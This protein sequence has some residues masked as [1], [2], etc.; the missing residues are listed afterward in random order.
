MKID[1]DSEDGRLPEAKWLVLAVE[2][3]QENLGF[4]PEELRHII[5][6]EV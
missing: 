1:N 6:Q 5:H 3:G 2:L 4:A